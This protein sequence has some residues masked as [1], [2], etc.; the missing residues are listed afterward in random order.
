MLAVEGRHTM[1][2]VT[3]VGRLTHDPEVKESTD[4]TVRTIIDVAVSR[5]Y[6][7]H[8]GIVDADFVRCILWNGIASAT[9]DYCHKGDVVGVRGKLQSRSYETDDNQKKY[10]TEVVVEKITFLSSANGSKE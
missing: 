6:K 8:D 7:N 10:V 3:L 2:N 9:K 4:G 5:D 1:N